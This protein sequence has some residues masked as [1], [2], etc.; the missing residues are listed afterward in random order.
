MAS[1][2]PGT[3]TWSGEHWRQEA[4]DLCQKFGEDVPIAGQ[5]N[6]KTD[7]DEYYK[8]ETVGFSNQREHSHWSRYS[9]Q[10]SLVEPFGVLS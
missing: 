9:A 7:Y 10:L 6:N 1:E 4:V 8:G 3:S 2:P 5:F